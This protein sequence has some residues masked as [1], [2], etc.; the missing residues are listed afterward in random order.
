MRWKV[1]MYK[2]GDTRVIT[3]FLW[4]PKTLGEERRWLEK[5]SIKQRLNVYTGMMR[6]RGLEWADEKWDDIPDTKSEF[7]QDIL[8]SP[9][10][11]ETIAKNIPKNIDAKG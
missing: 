7:I 4:F 8:S 11:R 6:I 3:K 9:D 2:A 5:A 1:K 10:G